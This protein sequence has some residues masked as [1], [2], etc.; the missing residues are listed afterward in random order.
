MTATMRAC[1]PALTVDVR[2]AILWW[3]LA[4][5]RCTK[6]HL[7]SPAPLNPRPTRQQ[8]SAA[9]TATCSLDE[10]LGTARWQRWGQAGID[11]GWRPLFPVSRKLL[12]FCRFVV[13]DRRWAPGRRCPNTNVQPL[14]DARPGGCHRQGLLERHDARRR[15]W[16]PSPLSANLSSCRAVRVPVLCSTTPKQCNAAVGVLPCV[17]RA[18]VP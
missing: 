9:N 1:C 12:S 17:P 16:A 18:G 8:T 2:S 6:R 11:R 13:Q 3:E 7:H 5:A 14:R 10:L 15:G 4:G